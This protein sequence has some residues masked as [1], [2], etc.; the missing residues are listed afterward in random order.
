[1]GLGCGYRGGLCM[2]KV[3]RFEVGPTGS[4]GYA[5]TALKLV[6]YLVERHSVLSY[7]L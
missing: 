4:V 3:Y 5:F 6:G 2:S 1:M 7:T